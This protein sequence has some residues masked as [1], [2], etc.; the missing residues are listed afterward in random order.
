MRVLFVP[1][2]AVF[3]VG[4][5]LIDQINGPDSLAIQR[6]LVS[7]D[8][9]SSGASVTL[10]WD[11]HGAD[12]VHIDNGV[13]TVPAKGT[14]TF[15]AYRTT[16]Y[17]LTAKAGTSSASASVQVSVKGS[18][19][20]PFV[21]PQPSPSP[22][23]SPSPSP[24]P[25]PSPSPSPSPASGAGCAPSIQSAGACTIEIERPVALPAGQCVE[26]VRLSA[27][28]DCPVGGGRSI[29]VD[30]DIQ[31]NVDKMIRW[32]QAGGKDQLSPSEGSL[33]AT[34]TSTMSVTDKTIGNAMH[35]EIVSADGDVYLR[36]SLQHR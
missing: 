18:T 6:F 11:V 23:P 3:L 15:S 24:E 34:G 1:A 26:L 14:K 19:S 33:Q 35:V 4:C 12:A 30:F 8:N 27:G 10:T 28:E 20:E 29:T 36:F 13:G 17:T 7:P 5:G 22:E 9:V 21:F 31:A 32:R 16:T 2:L 25:S